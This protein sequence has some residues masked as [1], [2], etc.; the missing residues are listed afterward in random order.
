[1]LRTWHLA[2]AD[3]PPLTF[4]HSY[5]PLRRAAAEAESHHMRDVGYEDQAAQRVGA[6]GNVAIA[7][8]SAV[9]LLTMLAGR[10]VLFNLANSPQLV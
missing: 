2:L 9:L 7:L 8:L 10:A 4:I 1:M 6:Q 3:P 5:A